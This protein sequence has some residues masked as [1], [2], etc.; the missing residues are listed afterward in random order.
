MSTD[1]TCVVM[2]ANTLRLITHLQIINIVLKLG[3]SIK[4]IT[5]T[6]PN[7]HKDVMIP[8]AFL[9]IISAKL[10]KITIPT[11]IPANSE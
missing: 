10:P 5:V 9:P 11:M 1:A 3:W 2:I 7:M 6:P 4:A 8:A